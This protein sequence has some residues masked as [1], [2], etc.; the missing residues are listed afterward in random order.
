MS[1]NNFLIVAENLLRF[2]NELL[3]MDINDD[4][5]IKLQMYQN[6]LAQLLQIT[7]NMNYMDEESKNILIEINDKNNALLE[8][9]K[10]TQEILKSE[11]NKVNKKEKIKKYYN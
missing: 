2:L 5:Y 7:N 4:F 3:D 8:R 9:L 11:I 6:F 1:K 10:K